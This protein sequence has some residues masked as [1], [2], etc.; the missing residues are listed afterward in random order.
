[1][2]K[3]TGKG[4]YGAIAVGKVSVFKRQEVL[5]KCRKVVDTDAEIMRFED[6]KKVAI[7]EIKEIYEKAL[8][9]VGEVNAQIFEIHM[10]MVEDEDYNDAITKK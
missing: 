1:M 4:V 3:F 7:A 6:A 8:K 10:M 2:K 9:E 5:V